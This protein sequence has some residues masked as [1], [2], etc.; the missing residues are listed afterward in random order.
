ME[1]VI[2]IPDNGLYAQ[3]QGTKMTLMCD[4]SNKLQKK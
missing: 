2:M 1:T 3:G 4:C